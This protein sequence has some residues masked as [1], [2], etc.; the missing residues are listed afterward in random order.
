MK[1]RWMLLAIVVFA[2]A[3]PAFAQSE[4]PKVEI[5]G[6]YSYF[7]YNPSLPALDNRSLDGGGIDLSFFMTHALGFKA[8]LLFY[9]ST[10]FT[11]T[12]G[13]LTTNRGFIPAGTYTS[14]GA[15]KT[16]LFGPIFKPR[17]RHFE[18]F[19]QVLFGVSHVDGYANLSR[20]ISV[21]PGSTLQVQG[22]ENPFTMAVG[23]GIDVPLGHHVALR[24]ADVDYVLTRLTNPL[25]LT[26]NQNNFRYAG[27]LQFR[28][29]GSH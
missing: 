22:N 21:T 19:V 13:N 2:M 28:F 17:A 14:N 27:G 25:T 7:R 29:G 6:E 24:L 11:S 10:S 3:I 9:G 26:N 4:S 23:G 1:Y 20:V 18:P 8:D 5:T 15:L 12:F 16:Y